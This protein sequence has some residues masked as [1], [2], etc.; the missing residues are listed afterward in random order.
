[1]C[2]IFAILQSSHLL[3]WWQLYTVLALH[4]SVSRSSHLEWFSNSLEGVPRGAEHLLATLSSLCGPSHPRPSHLGLRWVI[5]GS[6]SLSANQMWWHVTAGCCDSRAGSVCLG[7]W[8][9]HQQ[10]HQQGTPIHHTSSLMLHCGKYTCRNHPLTFS[11][12]HRDMV[13]GTK[14]FRFPLVYVNSLC[15]LA[16]TPLFFF[17]FFLF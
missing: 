5:V 3:L 16:Q 14:I 1:M 13:G 6:R 2:F 15:F 12:T 4:Q 7:F 11:A 17:F 9:N 10:C 8:I